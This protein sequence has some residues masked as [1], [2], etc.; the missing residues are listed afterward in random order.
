MPANSQYKDTLDYMFAQLP[1]YQ[2]VGAAAYK[3]DLTNTLALCGLCNNPQND[4]RCIHIAGTNGKGTTSHIVAAGLQAQGYKIGVYTSP[5]YKDFRERIKINGEYISKS[6]IVDF[7]KRYKDD[8]ERIKPS[9]FEM[10]VALAFSYFRDRKVDYCVIETGLGGRLDSTNVI[11]PM[12]SIIT[13]I[14]KDHVNMLGDTLPEIAFEK[15]GIIKPSVDVVIG[16]GQEE[17]KQ[18]FNKK[19]SETKSNIE[20]ADQNLTLIDLGNREYDV[21][22]N[23]SFWIKSLSS[24]LSGPFMEQNLITGLYALYKLSRL[25]P[26]DTE[27]FKVFFPSMV[28]KTKYLGRW[29]QLSSQ[30]L[31]IADSAHNEGGLKSVMDTLAT[32][33]FENLHIVLG[34]VNDKDVSNIL[35]FFP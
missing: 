23:N 35:A 20:W 3:K 12:L 9:F 28:E 25:V 24:P 19:A 31:I 6:Y 18:V 30:P 26:F 11:V 21:K 4:L 15:A 29:V 13:N 7:V 2:R 14:S 8:F 1:M 27:K 16:E 32:Y 17:V 5:H 34:F 33:N 22:V 10:T